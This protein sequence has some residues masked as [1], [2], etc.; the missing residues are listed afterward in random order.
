MNEF[1]ASLYELFVSFFG[2]DLGMHLN[3]YHGG[4][5]GEP[6]Y[7]W[8]GLVLTLGTVFMAVLFYYIINHPRFN[9]WKHWLIILGAALLIQFVVAYY[10]I[11]DHLNTGKICNDLIVSKGD[12]TSFGVVHVFWSLMIFAGVSFL[13]RWWSR[14][15]SCTPYPL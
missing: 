14:N 4:E 7:I 2:H 12:I 8:F 3:G 10:W 13:I 1:F 5:F 6:Y 15:C 9:K 11:L